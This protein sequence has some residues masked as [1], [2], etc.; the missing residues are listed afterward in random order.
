MRNPFAARR[1]TTVPAPRGVPAHDVM[2]GM[3]YLDAPRA[4]VADRR[5]AAPDVA[6]CGIDPQVP[7][8]PTMPKVGL[9]VRGEGPR[10]DSVTEL[11]AGDLGE[12]V[13]RR[14]TVDVRP[15]RDV[16]ESRGGWNVLA[17][18]VRDPADRVTND[19]FRAAV[20]E[21]PVGAPF[22]P[23]DI[24][25][26]VSVVGE[27]DTVAGRCRHELGR[28]RLSLTP[29]LAGSERLTRRLAEALARPRDRAVRRCLEHALADAIAELTARESGLTTL[30]APP[31]AAPSCSVP[32]QWGAGAPSTMALPAVSAA[33]ALETAPESTPVGRGRVV[34]PV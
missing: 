33:P 10:P 15:F 9:V 26:D 2:T 21:R 4:E 11:L 32:G 3:E 8:R 19:V 18:L 30:L 16:L 13:V 22:E 28:A 29:F 31:A 5:N 24:D 23:G 6:V 1:T 25:C 7:G 27:G 20:A 14:V 12:V 34:S 17:Q